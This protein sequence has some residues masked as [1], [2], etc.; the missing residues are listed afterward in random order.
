M[1]SKTLPSIRIPD[2]INEQMKLALK[3]LNESSLVE[4]SLQELRRMSYIYFCQAVLSGQEIR[5]VK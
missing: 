2:K 3:K 5:L 1:N 4:I